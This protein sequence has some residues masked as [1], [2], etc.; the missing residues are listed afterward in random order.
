MFTIWIFDICNL[1]E[2]SRA[3][4]EVLPPVTDESSTV[5]Q[6]MLSCVHLNVTYV[7]ASSASAEMHVEIKVP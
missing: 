3:S 1:S 4:N 2:C 5:T 6:K 7:T